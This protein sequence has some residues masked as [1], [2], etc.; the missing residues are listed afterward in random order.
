MPCPTQYGLRSTQTSGHS[1][2][3]GIADRNFQCG[4]A[5][6]TEKNL[7]SIV[8]GK[9]ADFVLVEG[10]PAEHISD[11]RRS[12]LVMKNWVVYRSAELYGAAGLKPAD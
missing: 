1:A 6:K 11:I 3:E 7:G 10:N 12:R 4:P 5:S 8:P 2:D 9:R